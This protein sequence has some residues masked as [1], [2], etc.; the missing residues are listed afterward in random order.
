M[1]E[2]ILVRKLEKKLKDKL[3]AE[4]LKLS[5]R[6]N[7]NLTDCRFLLYSGAVVVLEHYDKVPKEKINDKTIN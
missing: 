1:C 6:Y 3:D 7:I 4:A 5:V 2:L